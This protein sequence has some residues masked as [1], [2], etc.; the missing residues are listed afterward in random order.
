ML[1]GPFR[2]S[3]SHAVMPG[4]QWFSSCYEFISVSRTNLA[5]LTA[6]INKY[7]ENKDHHGCISLQYSSFSYLIT[8]SEMRKILVKHPL[9][10][11][12]FSQ[13]DQ[14]FED[15]MQIM[16]G[17]APQDVRFLN[18]FISVSLCI[19]IHLL[20]SYVHPDVLVEGVCPIRR[21]CQCNHHG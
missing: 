19:P 1:L 8:L 12:C 21:T 5:L 13:C 2:S 16:K 17:I 14:L 3:S 6:L 11:E 10:L 7:H 18:Q 4:S 15:V 20:Y 9:S